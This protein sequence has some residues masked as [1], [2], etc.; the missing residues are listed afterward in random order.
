MELQIQTIRIKLSGS[1]LMLT[2]PGG[3]ASIAI[4]QGAMRVGS[5]H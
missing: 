5:I 1:L 4:R 3:C 2:S